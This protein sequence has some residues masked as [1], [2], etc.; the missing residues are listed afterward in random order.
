MK[1][2]YLGTAAAEGIPAVFCQCD[3]CKSAL[4]KGGKDVRTRNSILINETILLDLSPDINW[5]R[6]RSGVDLSA[7]T[8]LLVTH[9]HSDHLDVQELTR[10]STANYCHISKEKPL[11]IY[12]N[13]K[14]IRLVEEALTVEFGKGEDPSI[15]ANLVS[16][17]EKFVVEDIRIL[18]LPAKHDPSE[19]CLIYLL[20]D[21]TT[22]MLIANDTGLMQEQVYQAIAEALGGRRLSLVSMDCTF[23]ARSHSFNGHMG[24]E[25]NKAMKAALEHYGCVGKETVYYLTHFSH[26]CGMNYQELC[27]KMGKVAFKIA[28]DGLS[29]EV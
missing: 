2:T 15:H 5:Q 9:S 3:T 16:P 1:L 4:K 27:E 21:E 26:N 29:V 25:E 28:Y 14:C 23:G 6:L 7:V 13:A 22:A 20:Q 19:E 17:F 8:S 10:R 11:Q 24:L 18:A 12:A